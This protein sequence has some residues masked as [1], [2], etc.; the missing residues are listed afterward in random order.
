MIIHKVYNFWTNRVDVRTYP[1]EELCYRCKG[2]GTKPPYY[3][4]KPIF[5]SPG[6][7]CPVC[8]GEGKLDWIQKAMGVQS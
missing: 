4:E 2:R 3:M 5:F 8:K 1:G 7:R 6:G